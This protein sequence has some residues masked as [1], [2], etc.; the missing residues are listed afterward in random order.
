MTDDY[1]RPGLTMMAARKAAFDGRGRP[2][3]FDLALFGAQDI[4]IIADDQAGPRRVSLVEEI[5]DRLATHPDGSGAGYCLLDGLAALMPVEAA[6]A[7]T[8]GLFADVWSQYRA[9]SNR[10][11]VD[12]DFF[13]TETLTGDG[14]IPTELFGSRWSFKPPH[15]DR[16]GVLFAHVYGP[17]AGFVGG[18]VFVI[19]ALA[20]T[21]EWA[22]DFDDA[23]TW[24]DEPGTQKPVLRAEHVGEALSSHGRRFGQLTADTI[25]F[26]N[27]G[28][29]GLLHGATDLEIGDE[30]R[31]ERSL[32]RVVVRER[33]AQPQLG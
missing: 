28:P 30:R 23:M 31:F 9:R 17:C 7:F 27:N 3:P 19:D 21:K 26:V 11:T 20:Y 18:D 32:Y 12:R 2:E 14:K 8:A 13:S 4:H 15:A 5:A 10:I 24:S 1:P 25:L 16:N 6:R 33:D 22:L 29:Q